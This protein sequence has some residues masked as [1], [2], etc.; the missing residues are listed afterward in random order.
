[1]DILEELLKLKD[2]KYRDFTAKL[3]PTVSKE[4][5]IGIRLPI[6]RELAKEYS[7]DS[8]SKDFLNNLPH[9]Y[10]EENFIHAFLIEQIKDLDFLL[11]S[12]NKFLPYVDNWAVCDSMNPKI[13]KKCSDIETK[14]VIKWVSS[15]ETY[16]IRY[17]VNI[18]M[19]HYLGDNFS[20]SHIDQL[21]KI[22]NEDYYVK[23]VVA[24]YL[25]TALAKKWDETIKYI[26]SNKFERWTHNKAIQKAIE[27]YRITPEQK[28]YLRTL[29]RKQ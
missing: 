4:T 29:K 19:R 13:F 18:L 26:E 17:G 10:F 25:A 5:I 3:N 7:K 12:L 15:K 28:E 23:M 8:S 27:S 16:T 9:K 21:T 24:W 6:L 2:E 1:M 14:Q 11:E 22:T 20:S